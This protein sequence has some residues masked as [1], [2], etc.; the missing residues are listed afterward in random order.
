ML[1]TLD[2]DPERYKE[3]YWSRFPGVYY[4]GDYAIRDDEGYFWLLGRADEV[5][6]IAGHRISTME[7]ESAIIE[8]PAVSEAAA[9]GKPHEVKGES[10]AIFVILRQGYKPAEELKNELR[11]HVRKTIGPVAT[12][13]EIYI[14]QSLP[15]TRSGKIM[16][17]VLK[18]VSM[19]KPIGDI[20]T[21][22]DEGLV[23]EVK[24]AYEEF[25]KLLETSSQSD[26]VK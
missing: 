13:D 26:S 1:M 20:S 25:K 6:K 14:G 19:G 12:P 22:E 10:V 18:A 5:L 9:I 7:L 15:K 16:R 4:A 8:H 2:K 3:V 24:R 23:D 21:L 11:E 17:R